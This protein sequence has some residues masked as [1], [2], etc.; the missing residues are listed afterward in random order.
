[1]SSFKKLDDF[2]G[3]SLEPRR[4]FLLKIKKTNKTYYEWKKDDRIPAY[5]SVI[6]DLEKD[7]ARLLKQLRE[8]KND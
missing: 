7:K 1:M 3:S 6:I 4:R 5:V 2:I 8:L